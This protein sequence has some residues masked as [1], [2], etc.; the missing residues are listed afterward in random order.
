MLLH[1]T[2]VRV[3]NVNMTLDHISGGGTAERTFQISRALVRSG[4]DCSVLILDMGLTPERI[5]AL[6]GVQ[7]VALPVF[8]R[9]YYVPRFSLGQI[10][11]VVEE[12]DVVQL[13]GHWTV[14][15]ALVY[16]FAWRFG[17]PYVVCPAGALPIYGRSKLLKRVYNRLIGRRIVKNADGHVAIVE[18][19]TPQFEIYGVPVEKVTVIPNGI[20]E[21]DFPRSDGK[22]FRARHGLGD[23]PFILFVGR[24]NHIKGPD[25]LLRAFLDVW[26]DL[27][28][29]HLVF[30]GPNDGMLPELRV[31]AT[32]YGIGDRVHFVGYLGGAA[33]AE[34]YYAADLLVIPSRQ[35]AM[36]I[37]ALEAGITGTPVLLTDR[38]GFDEVEQVGGGQVVPASVEGLRMGLIELLQ[39]PDRLVSM[40][41]NLRKFVKTRFSWDS[42]ADL[43]VGVYDRI[44]KGSK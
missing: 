44:L 13:M 23:N 39:E 20:N 10:R 1:C 30:V 24:L 3:L 5:K 12:A 27:P 32:E 43:Y 41:T 16:L 19:E 21:E 35:E 2:S 38:C 37:V 14:I 6:A 4:N 36:S 34:A 11:S 15:N 26:D 8:V 9:R 7:V 40:G 18:A 31:A 42:A 33:K 25:L 29:Y 28:N 17:K 22:N